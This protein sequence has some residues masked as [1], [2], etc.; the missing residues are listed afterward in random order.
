VQDAEEND[1][2]RKRFDLGL[3]DSMNYIFPSQA[4]AFQ[5]VAFHDMLA[6]SC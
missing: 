1:L 3:S 2:R 5:R 6:A 4:E